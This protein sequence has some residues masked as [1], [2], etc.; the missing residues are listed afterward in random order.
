MK[1]ELSE[2]LD[3]SPCALV[4]SQFGWTGNMERIIQS[5]T[6]AKANDMSRE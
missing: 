3:S 6:H 5:Q 1:A 4:S 2:R